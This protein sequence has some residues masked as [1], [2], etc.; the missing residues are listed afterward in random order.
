[1]TQATAASTGALQ[2]T[3]KAAN[4]NVQGFEDQLKQI[5]DLHDRVDYSHDIAFKVGQRN[6]DVSQRKFSFDG[7]HSID[8]YNFWYGKA[9]KIK[10]EQ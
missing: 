2:K 5:D 6:N 10:L 3:S 4:A 7:D 9:F 1:M 8:A